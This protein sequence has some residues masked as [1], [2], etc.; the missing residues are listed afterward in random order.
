VSRKRNLYGKGQMKGKKESNMKAGCK[1]E[2][3][4]ASDH[5]T[6]MNKVNNKEQQQE[7][8]SSLRGRDDDD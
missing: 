5:S 3:E 8:R 1:E 7:S 2:G 6:T 4:I